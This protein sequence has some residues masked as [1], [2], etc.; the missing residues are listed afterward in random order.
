[1]INTD[2]YICYR[3][4]DGI[5]VCGDYW[6]TA[7]EVPSVDST[8]DNVL[9]A[10]SLVEDGKLII[11]FTRNLD[12]GDAD[13]DFVLVADETITWGWAYGTHSSG[14]LM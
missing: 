11:A 9:S 8:T 7:E 4:S 12:T 14:T 13:E 10:I 6:S 3:D 5:P 1:M 2:M